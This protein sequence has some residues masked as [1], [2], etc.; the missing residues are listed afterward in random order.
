[1]IEVRIANN[2]DV[3][4]LVS[5][6]LKK[7][8]ISDK[9]CFLFLNEKKINGYAIIKTEKEK[10]FIEQFNLQE[11]KKV[12]LFFLKSIGFNLIEFGIE[13][14][15]DKN[16]LVNSFFSNNGK[17]DLNLLFKGHCNDL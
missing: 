16:M 1:M 8:D 3:D 2:N 11:N 12:K 4:S 14:I 7:E 10:S 6:G 17:I 5:L 9:F 13:E 15:Y